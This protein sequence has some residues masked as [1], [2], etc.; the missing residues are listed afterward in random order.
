MNDANNVVCPNCGW[1]HV[2]L[3]VEPFYDLAIVATLLRI[4]KSALSRYINRRKDEFPARY[5]KT[6]H[7][8]RSRRYRVLTG[9]EIRRIRAAYF[10][11]IL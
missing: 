2:P 11:E 4:S 6:G 5:R 8:P 3:P 1:E 10:E 7:G 9:E